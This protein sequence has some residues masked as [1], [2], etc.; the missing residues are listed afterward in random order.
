MLNLRKFQKIQE[1]T[2]TH[3]VNCQSDDIIMSCNLWKTPPYTCE[4]M[5]VKKENNI[6]K[7]VLIL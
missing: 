3:S 5:R 2:N 7:R 6:T 4:I 1:Y